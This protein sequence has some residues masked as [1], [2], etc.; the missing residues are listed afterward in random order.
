MI[1]PLVLS[2]VVLFASTTPASADPFTIGFFLLNL[3]GLG[4]AASTVV[5]FGATLGTIVGSLVIT[6]V[7]IGAQFLIGSLS[8]RRGRIPPTSLLSGTIERQSVT[9]RSAVSARNVIYGRTKIAGTAFFEEARAGIYY[10]VSAIM[11]GEIDGLEEVYLG[12][13]LVTVDANGWVTSAPWFISGV[14]TRRSHVRV[15]VVSGTENQAAFPD[16]VA[17]F[18][19]IWTSVHRARGVAYV[20]AEFTSPG[21]ARFSELYPGG[22]PPDV[23]VTVRGRRLYDPRNTGH[24]IDEP[25]TWNWSD[26]AALVILDWALRYSE[27]VETLD[28]IDIPSF[29]AFANVCDELVDT[30]GGGAIKR[31]T[32]NGSASLDQKWNEIAQSFCAACAASL[33]I[34]PDGRLTIMGGRYQ[35]PTL[36]FGPD[37]IQ[38]DTQMKVGA[39]IIEMV[40]E[41]VTVYTSIPHG[42]APQEAKTLRNEASI[43]L[44]GVRTD[45]FKV[46]WCAH[47]NQARRL[48]KIA[49]ASR[50]PEFGLTITTN[51][52]GFSAIGEVAVMIT[53][54]DLGLVDAP[55]RILKGPSPAGQG[56]VVG[57]VQFELESLAPAS[58]WEMSP[59]EEGSAPAVPPD[60]RDADAIPTP[61]IALTFT[62]TTIT[63]TA[64]DPGRT[65]LSLAI[66]Y[67]LVVNPSWI[68]L[69]VTAG[70]RAATTPTLAAGTWEVRGRWI[71]TA[72]ST[73]GPWSIPQTVIL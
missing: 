51:L 39:P 4:A 52:V 64:A 27:D 41:I 9:V 23:V 57:A 70:A 69:A 31:W 44:D 37:E 2:A 53:D 14:A 68:N 35:A 47:H 54:L 50:N 48:A 62:A 24:L 43:A 66:E 19:G 12:E 33:G 17:A 11:Q 65:T 59:F 18:P 6:A 42:W 1:M 29:I 32:L 63:A 45:D 72:T 7:L 28:D 21:Q 46:D 26:N 10:R 71:V 13:R 22:S 25:F 15:R 55:F 60:T 16:L 36:S 3:A 8:A 49:M 20:V 40:N 38:A 58:A 56:G 73:P 5:F 61:S 67:K 34:G 30:N